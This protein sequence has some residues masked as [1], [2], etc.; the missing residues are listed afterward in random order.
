[1]KQ[2]PEEQMYYNLPLTGPPGGG[3]RVLVACGFSSHVV[4]SWRNPANAGRCVHVHLTD[5]Q[6][7]E[8]RYVYL[9]CGVQCR[10]AVLV[11]AT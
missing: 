3:P 7:Q 10:R 8:Y 11:C 1:M 9:Y 6:M 4:V 5:N 2:K